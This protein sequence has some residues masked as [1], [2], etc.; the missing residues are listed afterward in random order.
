M[1]DRMEYA[2][3]H[4]EEGR[5]KEYVYGEY[6]EIEAYCKKRNSYVDRYLNHVDPMTVQ[7]GFRYVGRRSVPPC[8]AAVPFEYN[9]VARD[10]QK[11]AI[12]KW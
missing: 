1:I 6:D 2:K 11:W 12:E 10:K 4:D 5:F 9:G 3:V 7:K 8:D